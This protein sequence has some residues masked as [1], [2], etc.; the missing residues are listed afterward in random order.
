M[1][2]SSLL[3]QTSQPG[4]ERD[5]VFSLRR[6]AIDLEYTARPLFILSAFQRDSLPGMIYVEAR[7]SQQV[8]QACNGLVGVYLSRGINLVPIDEMS[9]LLQIKKQDINVTPGSWVRMKRG[10][11]QGD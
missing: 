10:K 1:L 3:T 4:R 6:K 2:S 8:S 11:Y 7:S 9:A 5:I